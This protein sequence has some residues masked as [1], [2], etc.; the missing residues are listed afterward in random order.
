MY[1][2]TKIVPSFP[3]KKSFVVAVLRPPFWKSKMKIV[4]FETKSRL[5]VPQT[6]EKVNRKRRK[7][8]SGIFPVEILQIF[9]KIDKK[10]LHRPG[11]IYY[12]S[13]EKKKLWC[14]DFLHIK[15]ASRFM[16][17]AFKEIKEK[18]FHDRWLTRKSTE[19]EEIKTQW[20]I[21]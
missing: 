18:F 15:I 21:A 8:T 2:K 19:T 12:A 4:D 13:K 6:H 3:T 1:Y 7:V 20:N 16:I 10:I 11:K 5:K 9:W 14:D 17:F